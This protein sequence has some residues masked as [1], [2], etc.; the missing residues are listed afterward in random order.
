MKVMFL[1]TG[2]TCRSQMA[3][4][5]A[6]ELGL[7]LIEPYSAGLVP[8]GLVHPAAIAVMSE[9]G[10]DISG[11]SSKGIDPA[12]LQQMDIIVTLCGNAEESCPVTP[13][14]ITR[15]HWPIDDPVNSIETAM[16]TEKEDLN[17]FRKARDEIKRK[18][19][20]LINSMEKEA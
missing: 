17:K 10:I 13:P 3:E 11:Q 1:C 16:G 15:L 9:E 6:R 14:E 18:I 19:T 4:G 5:F 7:G 2:N 20:G 8:A 12:L